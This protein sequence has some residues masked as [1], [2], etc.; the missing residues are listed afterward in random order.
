[1][2]VDWVSPCRVLD[3]LDKCVEQETFRVFGAIVGVRVVK[4][5]CTCPEWAAQGEGVKGRSRY[6]RDL[7]LEETRDR[8]RCAR[9]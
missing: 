6:S 5:G 7:S 9:F 4:I 1:V 3:C 8:C 2:R